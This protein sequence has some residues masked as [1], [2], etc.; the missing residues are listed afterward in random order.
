MA[1]DSSSFA[2]GMAVVGM[3]LLTRDG[4]E[5]WVL[6]S[7]RMD[8]AEAFHLNR[9]KVA[10]DGAIYFDDD[11][12]SPYVRLAIGDLNGDGYADFG[13]G[14]PGAGENNGRGVVRV[15]HGSAAPVTPSLRPRRASLPG[16]PASRC[17]SG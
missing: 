4:G 7:D 5:T 15:F 2:A 16:G 6:E 1:S 17:R 10:P 14:E 12:V 11:R 8:N 3:L 9:I 13:I